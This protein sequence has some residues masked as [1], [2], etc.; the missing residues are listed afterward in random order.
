MRDQFVLLIDGM[1]GSGK[2][3]ATQYLAQHLPRTAIIGFDKIKRFVTDFERG[4][5]DNAI[6]REVTYVMA[7]KYLDLGLSLIVD[8]PISDPS[9]VVRYEELAQKH[10]L[11][12]HKF[13][14]FAAPN[15]AYSRV[16]ERQ[17]DREH[18]VPEE[19]I[20]RNIGLFQKK[21]DLGFTLIDTSELIAGQAGEMI[22]KAIR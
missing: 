19:R 22:L 20:Q 14:L 2:T 9:E 10:S 12:C 1:T 21:D 6:A 4:T 3:T 13:Q 11:P 16:I 5:R 7:Q 15:I 17:K 18:K 8:Q